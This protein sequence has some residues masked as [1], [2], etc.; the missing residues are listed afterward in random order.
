V[1]E[2]LVRVV[3]PYYVAGIVLSNDTVIAA[4]P[5]LKWTIGKKREWL[6]R[7]FNDK[8]WKASVV[9]EREHI[10]REDVS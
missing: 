3:T 10:I 1:T 5:I 9:V 4:A 2:I 6:R 8:G 7:Y